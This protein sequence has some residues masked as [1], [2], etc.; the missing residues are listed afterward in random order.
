[1]K[2]YN[3]T[4]KII[5]CIIAVCALFLAIR[6]VK[7]YIKVQIANERARSEYKEKMKELQEIENKYK[8]GNSYEKQEAYE[9]LREACIRDGFPFDDVVKESLQDNNN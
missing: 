5:I 8:Y 7:I 6:A 9:E 1:M 4:K 3:K 2:N